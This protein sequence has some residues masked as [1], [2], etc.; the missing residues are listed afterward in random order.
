MQQ[1]ADHLKR[2]VLMAILARSW[3]GS[4]GAWVLMESLGQSSPVLRG[5]FGLNLVF[6][7]V[8]FVIVWRRLLPPRIVDMACLLFAAGL[9]AACMA[10]RLYSPTW[11]ASIDLQP[12][13]LW[14]R[15]STSSRS[16]SR[17][18]GPA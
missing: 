1:P 6:H 15:S 2:F 13:Y 14:I 12:L 8:M 9:C 16:R 5:V 3:L 17:G 7:P 11:G 10:L 18:I 4:G